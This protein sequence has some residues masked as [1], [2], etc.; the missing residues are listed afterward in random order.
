MISFVKWFLAAMFAL[1]VLLSF[2][3][4]A[5][6]LLGMA[7][8]LIVQLICNL[9]ISNLCAKFWFEDGEGGDYE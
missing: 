6:F 3:K 5:M 8:C 2:S 7:S 4:F 9:S 1:L